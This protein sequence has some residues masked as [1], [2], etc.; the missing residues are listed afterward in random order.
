MLPIKKIYIDSRQK[1]EDSVSHTD[2]RVD[3]P[4][5][6]LELPKNTGF[7]ITDITIPISF[8]TIEKGRNDTIYFIIGPTSPLENPLRCVKQIPEGNY[9]LVSLNN[10]IADIMNTGYLTPS[11]NI[12]P[13]KFISMPNL[14]TNKIIIGNEFNTFEIL[15]DKQ[16]LTHIAPGLTGASY[17]LNSIN[18]MIQNFTPQTILKGVDYF[19]S[20]YVDLFPIRNLYIV[21]NSLGNYSSMSL[22]GERGILK[23]I[24]VRASYNE[25]LFDQTILGMDYLDCSNQSISTLDFKLK[26]SYNNTIDLHGN[27]WSFSIIFVRINEE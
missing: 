2:F 8:Y 9:N 12:I 10:A 23:K 3:L 25:L 21:S 15:T 11:N 24:P 5:G 20:G 1:T 18:T 14:S 6:N 19:K 27:H 4:I 13:T 26:D 16:A 17:P 22:N 7:Y